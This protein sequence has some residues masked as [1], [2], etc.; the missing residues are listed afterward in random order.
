M[1]TYVVIGSDGRR[2]G[3]ADVATI[4][5]WA[6]EGRVVG[7]TIL[8]DAETNAQC[9][10]SSIP[11]IRA[12]LYTVRADDAAAPAET[13]RAPRRDVMASGPHGPAAGVSPFP[14]AM[15]GPAGYVPEVPG[16]KSKVVAGVLG[17]VFGGIGAHRFY[18]GYPGMGIVIIL[19]NVCF[20]FGVLWGFI[21]G[22]LCLAG[23]LRD[24]DG[25]LLRD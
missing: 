24:S 11:E 8:I 1:T 16:P 6:A 2:Y 14:A 20:G 9:A 25:R 15:T 23:K 21:E 19:S 4:A 5:R 13:L 3:P 18:L 22:I 17:L 12:A 10:A 7:G